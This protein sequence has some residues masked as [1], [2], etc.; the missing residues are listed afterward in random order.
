VNSWNQPEMII[1]ATKNRS[2]NTDIKKVRKAL[3]EARSLQK[4]FILT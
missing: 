2:W 1:E 3:K 4:V